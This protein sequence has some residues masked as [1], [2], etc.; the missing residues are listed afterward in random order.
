MKTR[1]K[2]LKGNRKV[3]GIFKIYIEQGN[4]VIIAEEK[5]E[6]IKLI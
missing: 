3:K 4:L 2:N 6:D 1:M 5:L